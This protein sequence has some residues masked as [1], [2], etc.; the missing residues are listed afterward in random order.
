MCRNLRHAWDINSFRAATNEEIASRS[1]NH[2][3]Q[4]IVRDLACLRCGTMKLEFFAR[5]NRTAGFVRAKGGY[6][7]PKGYL[8]NANAE[9]EKPTRWDYFETLFERQ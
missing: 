4:V 1:L 6:Q 5:D 7:Y 2:W 9:D 8:F 3:G